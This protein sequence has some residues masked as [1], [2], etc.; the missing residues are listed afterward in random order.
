MKRLVIGLIIV[1]IVLMPVVVSAQGENLE[2]GMM[3]NTLLSAFPNLLAQDLIQQLRNQGYGY[4]EIAIMCVIASQSNNSL[5]DVINYAEGNNVGWGEVASHFGIKLSKIGLTLH[6][7]NS[8]ED[9][10]ISYLLRERYGLSNYD[11][12]R[13][14]LE[15][16]KPQDILLACEI[17][18]RLDPQGDNPALLQNILTEREQNKNWNKTIEQLGL[19][20]NSLQDIR[21]NSMNQIGLVVKE[22]VQNRLKIENA[23][24]STQIRE[25]TRTEEEN[26]EQHEMQQQNQNQHEMHQENQGQHNSNNRNSK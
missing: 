14:R 6:S 21:S 10:A 8:T 2:S 1:S 17:Y 12:Y 9:S 5:T 25:Q 13:L 22:T 18:S 23:G 16:L 19:D 3:A 7:S 20:K 4:G 26:Q 15:G 24:Q 11:I